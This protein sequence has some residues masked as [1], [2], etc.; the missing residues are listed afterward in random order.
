MRVI[1]SPSISTSGFLTCMFICLVLLQSAATVT[2]FKPA[3]RPAGSLRWR[4]GQMHR[5]AGSR[6]PRSRSTSTSRLAPPNSPRMPAIAHLVAR[7]DRLVIRVVRKR[8]RH[9]AKVDQVGDVDALKALGDHGLDAQVHRAERG[10][11]AAG[12]LAIALAGHDHVVHARGR[13]SRPRARE[14]VGSTGSKTNVA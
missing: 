6:V 7:V 10:V 9:D 11:L 4:A 8:K 5:P 12:A 14:K 2:S 1:S 3:R 13:G